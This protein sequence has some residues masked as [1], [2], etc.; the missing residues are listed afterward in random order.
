MWGFFFFWP[1]L[2][3]YDVFYFF[4]W[5]NLSILVFLEWTYMVLMFDPFYDLLHCFALAQKWFPILDL[6]W[7][8]MNFKMVSSSSVRNAVC[9]PIEISLSFCISLGIMAVLTMLVL[10]IQGTQNLVLD[11]QV[12][13]HWAIYLALSFH[14]LMSTMISFFR[15]L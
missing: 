3:L 5:I 8:H 9:I 6:F 13:H 14:F 15:T 7:L 12:L 4:I 2:C 11:R 10:P 1:C